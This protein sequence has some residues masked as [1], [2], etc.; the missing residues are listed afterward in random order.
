MKMILYQIEI[1]NKKTYIMKKIQK[2]SGVEKDNNQ[3]EKL[4]RC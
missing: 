3:N 1:I 4:T 2:N